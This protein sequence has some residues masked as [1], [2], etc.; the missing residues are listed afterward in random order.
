MKTMGKFV[1][2]YV[3]CVLGIMALACEFQPPGSVPGNVI[4]KETMTVEYDFISGFDA[5]SDNRAFPE[6]RDNV[7]QAYI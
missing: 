4:I 2:F 1:K 3:G 7:K 5:G 6:I